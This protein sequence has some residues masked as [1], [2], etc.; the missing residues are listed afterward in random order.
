MDIFK[1]LYT[2]FFFIC[3][4]ISVTIIFHIIRYSYNKAAT[5]LMLIVFIVVTSTLLFANSV[6]FSSMK[7]EK[8]LPIDSINNLIDSKNQD[9]KPWKTP[10]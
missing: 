5:V 10:F 3:I 4:A 2:V 1:I 9:D 8:V 7:L 6:L